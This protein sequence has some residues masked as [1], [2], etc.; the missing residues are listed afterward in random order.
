MAAFRWRNAMGCRDDIGGTGAA[1]GA[2]AAPPLA[3]RAW[4]SFRVSCAAATLNAFWT[5]SITCVFTKACIAPNMS[6]LS[7]CGTEKQL[8]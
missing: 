1:A 7:S 5:R 2:A 3:D 6:L 8:P 4:A